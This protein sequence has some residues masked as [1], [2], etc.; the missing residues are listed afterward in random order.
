M[1]RQKNTSLKVKNYFIFPVLLRKQTTDSAKDY[2]GIV[3]RVSNKKGVTIDVECYDNSSPERIRIKAKPEFWINGKIT[4]GYTTSTVDR[5]NTCLHNIQ[6]EIAK[7]VDLNPKIAKPLLM[8]FLY[9]SN[10]AAS[11]KKRTKYVTIPTTYNGRVIDTQDLTNKEVD[12]LLNP[13][14]SKQT[15]INSDGKEKTV[16]GIFDSDTGESMIESVDDL[17]EIVAHAKTTQDKFIE[18]EK[19]KARIASLSTEQRYKEGQFN[20][21][22]ICEIFALT[23]YDDRITNQFYSKIVV[24]LFEYKERTGISTHIKD[25]NIDW[26]RNYFLWFEENGWYHIN[27]K[28]FDPLKYDRGMFFKQ[29]PRLEYK[30]KTVEKNVNMFKQITAKLQKLKLLP[31]VDGLEDFNFTEITKKK[32]R[33]GTR[34]EHALTKDEFDTIFHHKILKKDLPKY[35]EI[36]KEIDPSRK[37]ILTIK[38]LEQARDMFVVEVMAG[39]LRGWHDLKTCAI[40]SHTKAIKK[41]ITFSVGK[42][43]DAIENPFNVYLK[44]IYTRNNNQLPFIDNESLYASLIRTVVLFLGQSVPDFDRE[45][46]PDK[47]VNK[48]ERVYD[49]FRHGYFARKT[50][51]QILRRNLNLNIED[52]ELFTGHEKESN[53]LSAS[54]L[55]DNTIEYKTKLLSKLK[56]GKGLK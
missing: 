39:G 24:R 17:Y 12:E 33:K 46:K 50:F 19:E 55:D 9:G 20:K 31:P 36:F 5:L 40:R 21:Q 52:I 18:S 49:L 38:Q 53:E 43:K 16:E 48:Y 13:Y 30:G 22:D 56:I 23:Y 45:I 15:F 35:Q 14:L 28:T 27:T 2:R 1:A 4:G 47:F 6:S 10:F 34:K 8:E 51:S 25:F 37:N 32:S 44:K 11:K 41:K 54:Y 26:I 42:K 7:Y 3:I 29:K